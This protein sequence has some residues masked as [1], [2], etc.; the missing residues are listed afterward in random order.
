[1]DLGGAV[2]DRTRSKT[3]STSLENLQKIDSDE[4]TSKEKSDKGGP[5]MHHITMEGLA[6]PSFSGRADENPQEWRNVIRHWLVLKKFPSSEQAMAALYLLLK[7]SARAWADTLENCRTVED[8][9]RRFE[10]R[11]VLSAN[12][13]VGLLDCFDIKQEDKSLEDYIALVQ[14]KAALANLSNDQMVATV[15]KGLR[16]S[17][18]RQVLMH[19]IASL[20]DVRKYG[21]MAEML[22]NESGNPQGLAWVAGELDGLRK[23][24]DGLRVSAVSA[25]A[26][27]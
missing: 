20:E 22:E 18:R 14:Q 2:G 26:R 11:Y 1:M 15:L 9:F 27:C 19:D 25:T 16:P 3:F 17:L 21:K 8:F 12:K 10:D 7:G 23:A 6:P 13:W 24:V 4:T 5:A